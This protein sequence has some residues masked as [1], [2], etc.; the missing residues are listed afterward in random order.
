[1]RQ[2]L[3]L[4]CQKESGQA[5]GRNLA[6]CHSHGQG[7]EGDTSVS[8][9]IQAYPR[10]VMAAVCLWDGEVFRPQVVGFPGGCPRRRAGGVSLRACMPGPECGYAPPC[11]FPGAAVCLLAERAHRSPQG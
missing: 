11:A 6:C 4:G 9:E 2:H 5:S 10:G 8:T 1:M 7:R 3:P